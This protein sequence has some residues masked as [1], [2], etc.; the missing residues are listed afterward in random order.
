L[1]IVRVKIISWQNKKVGKSGFT[2]LVT[3]CCT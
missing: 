2:I 3:S 1:H